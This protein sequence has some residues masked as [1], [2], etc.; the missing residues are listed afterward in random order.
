MLSDI[1]LHA[2]GAADNVDMTNALHTTTVGSPTNLPISE[3]ITSGA[4]DSSN[5]FIEY[6]KELESKGVSRR[7]VGLHNLRVELRLE[8]EQ[9]ESDCPPFKTVPFVLPESKPA[10]V[11]TK[12]KAQARMD[13]E[14][15]RLDRQATKLYG[16]VFN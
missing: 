13:P 4:T 6:S 1:I 5:E 15:V 2:S 9:A 8:I 12:K 10:S 7:K 3:A 16:D 14:T 11:S